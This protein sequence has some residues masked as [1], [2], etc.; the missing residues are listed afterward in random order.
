MKKA[1]K[2]ILIFIAFTNV[3]HAQEPSTRVI[4]S[5]NLNNKDEIWNLLG[6][7]VSCYEADVMYIYGELFVTASMPDSVSH[8]VPLFSD[9]YLFPLFSN[10][11]KNGNSIISGDNRESFIL[12]NVHNELKKTNK[13]LKSMIGPL[14]GLITY[15][16]DGL[17]EG[18]VRLLVKNK[19]FREEIAKDGYICLGLVGNMSDIESGLEYFQMPLIELDFSE[20]TTWSGAGNIPFPDYVKI[21]ELVNKIH[22]KGRKISVINCPNHKTAWEVLITSKVDFINTNDPI[23]V[24]NY[25]SER[26]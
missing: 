1:I 22:Q 2:T 20:L 9:A 15:N 26:K 10:L 23:N 3:A 19:E 17:H 18:K 21:K 13:E 11:K 4:S 8:T 6:H 12:L 24:C 14:K 7:G 16:S 25:L 5:G